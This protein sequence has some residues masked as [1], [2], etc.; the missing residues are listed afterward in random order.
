LRAP[1]AHR[2][3]SSARPAGG[4]A[5][6][7]KRAAI[8]LA[9]ALE[10]TTAMRGARAILRASAVTLAQARTCAPP[11]TQF[12]MTAYAPACS[13]IRHA[14]AGRF[15][16]NIGGTS[17][18]SCGAAPRGTCSP[19]AGAHEVID[20]APGALPLLRVL[21]WLHGSDRHDLALEYSL[22]SAGSHQPDEG[23]SFCIP[24]A[25]GNYQPGGRAV[26]CLISPKGSYARDKGARMAEQCAPGALR[27]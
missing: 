9:L 7:V 26:E 8:A 25:F 3:L 6:Q 5:L 12:A 24:C 2:N 19:F 11:L 20:C 13:W 10:G 14:A 18:S 1:L 22:A 27:K 21:S 4:V 23:Q 15:Y 17:E 16:P